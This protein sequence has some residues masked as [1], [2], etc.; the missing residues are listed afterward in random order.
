M[1]TLSERAR[2]CRPWKNRHVRPL[3]LSLI[4]SPI[5]NIHIHND[6]NQSMFSSALGDT[7][8]WAQ[9]SGFTGIQVS[10]NGSAFTAASGVPSGS[11]IASDKQDNTAFYAVSGSAFY[12]STDGGASFAQTATLG[13]A[14]SSTQIAVNPWKGGEVFVS[15]GVGVFHSTYVFL[16][17]PT[18]FFALILPLNLP[19]TLATLSLHYRQSLTP[20]PSPSENPIHPIPAALPL[21][22]SPEQLTV[23]I[24]SCVR[25]T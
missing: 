22:S 19:A 23:S 4:H 17:S 13:D 15:T 5:S 3:T 1:D 20:G 6:Q 9:G 11:A 10:K 18:G 21:S 24:N 7:L 2:Q 8:L 12:A 16:L 25:T 14:G